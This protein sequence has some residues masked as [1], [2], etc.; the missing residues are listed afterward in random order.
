MA[1]RGSRDAA[2]WVMGRTPPSGH[3]AVVSIAEGSVGLDDA[4]SSRSDVVEAA[5]RAL[6]GVVVRPQY[7]YLVGSRAG[8]VVREVVALSVSRVSPF[9]PV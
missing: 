8:A 5:L 7:R 6:D 2:S 4:L 1:A 3:C 9:V